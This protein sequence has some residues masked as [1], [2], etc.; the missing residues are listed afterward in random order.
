MAVHCVIA[1][2]MQLYVTAAVLRVSDF[3]VSTRGTHR[4]CMSYIALQWKIKIPKY[5]RYA[6]VEQAS[7]RSRHDA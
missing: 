1:R 6:C 7:L 5:D 4:L 3:Y 2:Y